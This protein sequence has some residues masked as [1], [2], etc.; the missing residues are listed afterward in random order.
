MKKVKAIVALAGAL[1]CGEALA[2]GNELLSEC[3]Y[4]I[5]YMDTD[6]ME[7][8]SAVGYC[9]GTVNGVISTMAS[10][11]KFLLP[12][13]RTCFPETIKNSQATRI[14]VKYLENHPAS[15]HRDGPFLA[16]AAFQNA[17]PCR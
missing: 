2:D 8:P 6:K 1:T 7:N 13:E 9:F 12:N 15:L 17:Y 11:N 5:R 10:M 3:Q 14:L 4:A 16:L